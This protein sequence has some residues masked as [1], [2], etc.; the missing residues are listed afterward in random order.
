MCDP[1]FVHLV[2]SLRQFPSARWP[3]IN[4][5]LP[6]LWPVFARHGHNVVGAGAGHGT[7]PGTAS[8]LSAQV[9]WEL[10]EVRPLR[11]IAKRGGI[12]RALSHCCE[13]ATSERPVAIE[14]VAG[15]FTLGTFQNDLEINKPDLRETKIKFYTAREFGRFLWDIEGTKL[16]RAY[17][18]FTGARIPN[19]REDFATIFAWE[20]L[21]S[22]TDLNFLQSQDPTPTWFHRYNM[23][24]QWIIRFS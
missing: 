1:G 24:R 17:E 9:L 12:V 20:V 6:R 15:G 4:Q 14:S 18:Q 13:A 11:Q 8:W 5:E 7:R 16:R 23:V 21:K 10:V 22:Q 19:A 3:K 2:A